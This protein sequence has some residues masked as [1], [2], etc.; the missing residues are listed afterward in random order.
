MKKMTFSEFSIFLDTVEVKGLT[1]NEKW[2]YYRM[3][4]YG[5]KSVRW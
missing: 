4:L 1:K 3:Y 2:H 5:R